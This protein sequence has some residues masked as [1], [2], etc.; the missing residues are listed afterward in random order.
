MLKLSVLINIMCF[1]IVLAKE[2]WS[3]TIIIYC[4]SEQGQEI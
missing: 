3:G 1:S 2:L 4:F